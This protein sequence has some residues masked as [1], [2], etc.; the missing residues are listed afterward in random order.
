MKYFLILLAALAALLPATAQQTRMLTADKHNE[1]GLVY[2]L[3]I[4]T[5]QFEVT[6][7]HTVA[8]AGPYYQYAKRFIGT[9]KVV[10][11]DNDTWQ[12][13]SVKMT[14]FGVADPDNEFLMQLKPG[15]LASI[16]VA[17][18][19]M[20]LAINKEVTAPASPLPANSTA[21]NLPTLDIDKYLDFVDEDFLASQSSAK[22][23][24][25]LAENIMEVR[26]SRVS[27]TRGTAETMPVDGRQLELM[28]QGLE[29]QEKAM[30]A[31]FTGMS[32]TETVTRTYVFTPDEAGKYVLFR[33]SDFAGF[34]EADD[35][36]GEPVYLT[37]DIMREEGLPV[38]AH[39]NEKQLPKDAVMYVIP[40]AAHFTLTHKN[41][42]IWNGDAEI[43]QYG[44]LF[45]LNPNLFTD[46]KQPSFATF[47]PVTGALVKIAEIT[48]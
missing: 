44:A 17:D 27:L 29:Q 18:D 10:K 24:Q 5:L 4:T 19:G 3:P 14:P 23:A 37:V 48:E 11:E 16:C 35:Y 21:N 33:M 6:A 12:I 46:K 40:G 7:R 15:A 38:D 25:M 41:R 47:D 32:E 1:Y 30:T 34:V 8:K 9:D 36:S 13:V 2:R 28:L 45:G 20:L 42:P 22:Q 39:G 31:A 26:D 43:S